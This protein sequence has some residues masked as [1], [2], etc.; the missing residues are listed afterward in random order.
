VWRNFHV[1]WVFE[2][3]SIHIPHRH[4]IWPK[5]TKC[6]LEFS[7]VD[8]TRTSYTPAIAKSFPLPDDC[9]EIIPVNGASRAIW[10]HVHSAFFSYPPTLFAFIAHRRLSRGSQIWCTL[11]NEVLYEITMRT[12]K[13]NIGTNR[14]DIAS[15]SFSFDRNISGN[16]LIF[17]RRCR[18]GAP[19]SFRYVRKMRRSSNTSPIS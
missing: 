14:A 16:R 4:R 17:I 19:C 3:T 8:N 5:R 6:I 1:A 15:F 9:K 10:S 2:E 13:E 11:Q 18:V 12:R 7:S